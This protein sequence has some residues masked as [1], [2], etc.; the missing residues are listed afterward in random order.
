LTSRSRSFFSPSFRLY[1]LGLDVLENYL[2]NPAD[3]P[4]GSDGRP[5]GLGYGRPVVPDDNRYAANELRAL[6]NQREDVEALEL[7]GTP[8]APGPAV[9][10]SRVQLFGQSWNEIDFSWL[11]GH[12]F[13]RIDLRWANLRESVW[14]GSS[15]SEAYLQC[16]DLTRANLIGTNLAGADLRGAILNRAKLTGANLA[17]ADLRA[18]DLSNVEGLTREQLD[19]ALWDTNTGGLDEDVVSGLTP[20]ELSTA[21]PG[22]TDGTCVG[23]YQAFPD[24]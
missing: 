8:Q 5:A 17:G 1:T 3:A 19:S 16:A 7:D 13:V 6:V 22:T 14:G 11:A 2:R 12:N 15:L 4:A 9:D 10:L 24:A 21:P 23:D 18:A 20:D